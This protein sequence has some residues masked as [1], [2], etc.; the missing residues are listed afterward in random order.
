MK[1]VHPPNNTQ[2]IKR[3][4]VKEIQKDVERKRLSLAGSSGRIFV[5]RIDNTKTLCESV[6]GQQHYS[7]RSYAIP[8]PLPGCQAK[9][10]QR[11]IQVVADSYAENKI[12]IFG[13]MMILSTNARLDVTRGSSLLLGKIPI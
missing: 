4:Y 8:L 12:K 6:L 9:Q 3:I 13:M 11:E 2:K 1:K 10:N 7:Q 5:L